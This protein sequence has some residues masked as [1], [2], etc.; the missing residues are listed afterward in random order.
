MRA[1]GDDEVVDDTPPVEEAMV[2]VEVV[3]PI[4]TLNPEP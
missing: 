1:A 3:A 2:E 4:L